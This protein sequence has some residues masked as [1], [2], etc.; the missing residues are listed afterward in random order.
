MEEIILIIY[1]LALSILF[2]F[3]IHG[4]ILLYYY[5]KTQNNKIKEPELPKELPMVTIQLPLYNEYF[6]VERLIRSVCNIKYPKE[7]L[8]IQVLDD[9]T[10]ES[11][12]L[13]KSLVEEYKKKGFNIKYI[14]RTDRTGYKAGALKHGLELAEGDFVAIFDAD[15]VPNENFLLKTIPYFSNPQIGMVQTRWEHLNEE[16][17]YLTRAQALALDGHFVLE[18]QV[19]NKAGFFINFNGTAGIWRKSAIIDAGNW[20]PDTL[21]EDLD[22]SYRAQLRGWKFVYLNDVT[23]PAELPADIN[24]LKTQ[25]FRWTKGAVETA[26]KLLPRVLK[27]DIPLKV[28]LECFVHLTSNIVFPFIIIV[29]LL[30]VPIVLIKNTVGGF[31]QFYSFMSIFV[32]ASISTFLFYM[33]AQKAIHLDWRRRLLLFPV[34]LAGSMGF[35]VNNT[36]AVLEALIGKKTGFA[37]T[38][39]EGIVGSAPKPKVKKYKSNKFSWTV[40][41]EILLA[42]YFVIGVGISLYYLEI[43]AIPFQLLFLLGFGTVGYLS[44]RHAI[45]SK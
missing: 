2:G 8:E 1:F 45:F 43:A 25:Q 28:K 27:A 13:C 16:Y 35:A 31:D 36:K 11:Q 30:N 26:K 20:E 37:R 23:S 5:R 3:G 42:L 22:L 4:L 9:S 24:A 38:P 41:F 44:L 29:A 32:L 34:F 12:E 7:K 21:T 6:V 10:D 15:F 19:R 33:Y 14:H 18:Q 17:S 40:L 39:K